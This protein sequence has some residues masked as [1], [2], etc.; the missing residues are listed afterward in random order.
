MGTRNAY[1]ANKYMQAKHSN[2]TIIKSIKV[3][4]R[5]IET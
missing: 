4:K 3:R 2:K 1:G 5:L